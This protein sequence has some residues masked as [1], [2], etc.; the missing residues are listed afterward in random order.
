MIASKGLRPALLFFAFAGYARIATLGEEVREPERTIPRAIP[1]GKAELLQHGEHDRVA[2]FALGALVPMAQQVAARLEGEGQERDE[3]ERER[4][5]REQVP[6]GDDGDGGDRR[7]YRRR[8][9][10][11][12]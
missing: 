1:I 9:T 4:Q 2:I 5:P 7:R 12:R 3:E 10:W 6:D 8:R 11:P